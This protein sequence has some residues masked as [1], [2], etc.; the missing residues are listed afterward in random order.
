MSYIIPGLIQ[1]GGYMPSGH[2]SGGDQA[3]DTHTWSQ[4]P[5]THGWMFLTSDR[6][7]RFDPGISVAPR[8]RR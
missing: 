3:T 5:D 6:D 1:L 4:G 7:W 8:Y 2:D